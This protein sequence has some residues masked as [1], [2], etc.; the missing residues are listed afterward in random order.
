MRSAL[1][2]SAG[3]RNRDD[4]FTELIFG[5]PIRVGHGGFGAG[6]KQKG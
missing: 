6:R 5:Y 3:E 1:E 4:L 2:F